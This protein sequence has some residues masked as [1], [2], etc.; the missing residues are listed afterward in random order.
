MEHLLRLCG[1]FGAGLLCAL[2]LSFGLPVAS[3]QAAINSQN[4]GAKYDATQSNITFR[5][6][7]SR[8]TRIEVCCI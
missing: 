3:A 2:V 8:A 4:L 5:I 7:S 6:Y 1:R